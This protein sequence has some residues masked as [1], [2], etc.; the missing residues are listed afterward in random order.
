[1]SE[2]T[3]PTFHK[4]NIQ[5]Q[6]IPS[7][8]S[9]PSGSQPFDIGTL[10]TKSTQLDLALRK[11][12]EKTFTESAHTDLIT[13]YVAQIDLTERYE[14]LITETDNQVA[15]LLT[16]MAFIFVVVIILTAVVFGGF[17]R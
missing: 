3:L 6:A 16:R 11:T 1:M 7:K 2:R 17:F 5:E 13:R 4:A 14:K 10:Q 9:A 15:S 8:L 12:G